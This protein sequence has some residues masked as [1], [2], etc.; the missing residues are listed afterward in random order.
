[1][2]YRFII[3][4][5]ILVF[6]NEI[7]IFSQDPFIL[8][9]VNGGYTKCNVYHYNIKD[10]KVDSSSKQKSQFYEF[11]NEGNKINEI[12][13]YQDGSVHFI[14]KY[15]YDDSRHI[16][17]IIRNL[18]ESTHLD[19][20]TFI[21]DEKGNPIKRFDKNQDDSI[22]FKFHYK[23]IY[24]NKG[25]LIENKWLNEIDSVLSTVT[26]KYDEK[27]NNNYIELVELGF[28]HGIYD[29]FYELNFFKKYD[30]IGN[31]I[32]E[33][34]FHKSNKSYEKFEYIYSK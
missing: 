15:I 10:N 34:V 22:I 19:K 30:D 17:E 31:M 13:Y 16:I 1:M 20:F 25:R 12:I 5:L 26:Y 24:D 6:T 7:S 27:G 18:Y 11:N 23:Y 28:F 32:E 9:K 14:C 2:I 8:K 33:I 3:I 4:I 21:N 29:G